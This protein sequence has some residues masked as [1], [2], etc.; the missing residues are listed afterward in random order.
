MDE[1]D[2][3]FEIENRR[4]QA[5]LK[6]PPRHLRYFEADLIRLWPHQFDACI[7]YLRGRDNWIR[8][9]LEFDLFCG[10]AGERLACSGAAICGARQTG[11]QRVLDAA[12]LHQLGAVFRLPDDHRRRE[13]I[14]SFRFADFSRTRAAF[15]SVERNRTFARTKN[16][17]VVIVGNAC[18][19]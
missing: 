5:Q 11:G 13:R 6:A 14:V 4:R 16:V 8:R 1:C 2:G 10:L 17:A 3:Q 9:V 19:A 15:D 12:R 7:S 18:D